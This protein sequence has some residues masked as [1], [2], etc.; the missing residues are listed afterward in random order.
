PSST[1]ACATR[2]SLTGPTSSRRSPGACSSSRRRG[3]GDMTIDLL[4][5]QVFLQMGPTLPLPAPFPV[6]DALRSIEV[7]MG[8]SGRDGLQLTFAVGRDS[9]IDSSLVASGLFEPPTRMVITAV[10]GGVPEVLIDGVTTDVQYSVSPEPGES[11]LHVTGEDL[12]LM[13]D[14]LERN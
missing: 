4:G 8:N 13:M 9:V 12:T 1:G 3:C 5:I 2:T 7:R 10:V 11:T 14:L 6:M